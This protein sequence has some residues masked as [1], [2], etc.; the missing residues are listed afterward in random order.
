[1]HDAVRDIVI[2]IIQ[3]RLG[4]KEFAELSLTVVFSTELVEQIDLVLEGLHAHEHDSLLVLA[5]A[6]CEQL[7]GL[8]IALICMMVVVVHL[9]FLWR[10]LECVKEER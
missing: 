9:L 4:K 10:R 2:Y 6:L 1:M 8:R 5:A 3:N 7:A